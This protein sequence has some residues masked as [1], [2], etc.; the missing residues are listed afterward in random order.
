MPSVLPCVCPPDVVPRLLVALSRPD[1]FIRGLVRRLHCSPAEF[2]VRWA[3]VWLAGTWSLGSLV[4]FLMPIGLGVASYVAYSAPWPSYRFRGPWVA[5]RAWMLPILRNGRV[6]GALVVRV[7]RLRARRHRTVEPHSSSV[8]PPRIVRGRSGILCCLPIAT[9]IGWLAIWLPARA[10][11][12]YGADHNHARCPVCALGYPWPRRSTEALIVLS[13]AE[14]LAARGVKY[15]NVYLL[16]RPSTRT[17]LV[18]R[19]GLP[20]A[21][22]ARREPVR[23]RRREGMLPG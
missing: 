3:L 12:G 16:H 15:P 10:P 20:D 8:F 23:G 7:G 4:Y 17:T 11:R 21:I 1:R 18:P 19:L 2:S 6:S 22:A 9:E 14:C 5:R 13:D